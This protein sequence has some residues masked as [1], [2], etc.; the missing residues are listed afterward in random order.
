MMINLAVLAGGGGNLILTKGALSVVSFI[1]AGF[2]VFNV[3][4]YY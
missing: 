3:L 4:P 2:I 1:L